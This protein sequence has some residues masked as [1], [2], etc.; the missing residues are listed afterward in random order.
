MPETKRVVLAAEYT[1]AVEDGKDK[2][3]KADATITL[4]R[5]EAHRL[6]DAGLA[7][8]PE[9]KSTEAAPATDKEK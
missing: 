5:H 9:P 8:L 1:E 2:V 6:L 7:R 4:P 3:H